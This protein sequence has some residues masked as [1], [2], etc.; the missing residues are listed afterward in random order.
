MD[1]PGLA[2]PL[3]GDVDT[4]RLQAEEHPLIE[5]MPPATA[6]EHCLRLMHLRA[7]DEAV[8]HAAGRDVLDIGCNTGY[9]TIRFAPV[10]GRVVG[11]DVSPRAID[12][13]R[14]RAPDGRPEFVL[15]S[16]FELPFPDDSFDLVTSFQVLEHVPDPLAYLKELQRVAHPG[17]IVILATPNAATRL[18]PGMTPWNRFHV[19]EY[20]ATE[21]RDLLKTVF[22]QVRIRG[23]F[24]TPTLYETEIRRVDAAR[25]R[26]RRKEEAAAA[27]RQATAA[28]EATAR[29]A[30]ATAT[31]VRPARPLALR[32]ARAFL[33]SFA[34]AWL[35]SNVRPEGTRATRS[36]SSPAIEPTTAAAV[37]PRSMDLETFLRFSV[38]DLFYADTDLDRAMD[39]LAICELGLRP[40]TA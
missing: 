16:G 7:Y 13:A 28:H 22:P 24:G 25:Q 2:Q 26:I 23:M 33:P 19:H 12:A 29:H 21:L 18:Y 5:D 32:V 15:T 6:A 3:E 10:A 35:R 20:V 40:P 34:R 14:Q 36:V 30:P 11:V 37:E 8:S 31:P 38:A 9:G 1:A 27:A 4:I 17:G 39:L